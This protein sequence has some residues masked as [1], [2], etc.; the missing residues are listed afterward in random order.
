MTRERRRRRNTAESFVAKCDDPPLQYQH[1][2]SWISILRSI[3]SYSER[4]PDQPGLE[5]LFPKWRI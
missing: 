2:D 4:A 5:I 1:S 3:L